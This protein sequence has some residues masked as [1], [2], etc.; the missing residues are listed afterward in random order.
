MES[1]LKLEDKLSTIPYIPKSKYAVKKEIGSEFTHLIIL[2][3]R[4][5]NQ[6]GPFK[7]E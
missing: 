2:F 1:R 6:N 3:H 4:E 5:N 7:N